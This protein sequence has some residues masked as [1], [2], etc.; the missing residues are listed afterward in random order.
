[1]LVSHAAHLLPRALITGSCPLPSWTLLG[2]Q[3]TT[4]LS[5]R[6]SVTIVWD[7]VSRHEKPDPYAYFYVPLPLHFSRTFVT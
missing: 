5:S 1:M 2:L 3:G 6:R 7:M 4:S